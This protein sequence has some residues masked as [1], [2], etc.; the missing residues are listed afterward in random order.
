MFWGRKRTT[1]GIKVLKNSDGR[2]EKCL[3]RLQTG[4]EKGSARPDPPTGQSDKSDQKVDNIVAV[5]NGLPTFRTD[6]ALRC[7]FL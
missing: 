2:V 4:I 3:G 5:Y 1:K 6:F 7:I